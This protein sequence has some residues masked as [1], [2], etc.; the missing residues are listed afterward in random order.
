MKFDQWRAGVVAVLAVIILGLAGSAWAE[1]P[2]P[3]PGTNV[4]ATS[5]S[6]AQLR[7]RLEKAI[8]ANG[9]YIVGQA[10]ASYGASRRKIKIP[11]NMIIDVFRND[12]AVRML[13][14]SVAAGIEA[15]LRFYLTEMPGGKATLTYRTPS[16][17]FAAYKVSALDPVARDLDAIWAK[18]V[19]AA[20]GK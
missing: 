9:M 18:I 6:F 2:T 13:K 7:Q 4:I 20:T 10:S 5:H 1:N 14:A 15:P 17:V 8:D 12:F 16:A 19:A 11:G 3:Y